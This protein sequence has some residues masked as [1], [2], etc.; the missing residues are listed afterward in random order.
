M[1]R[2]LP[3][4]AALAITAHC[5]APA[6]PAPTP[7]P[8]PPPP[9]AAAPAQPAAIGTVRVTAAT[10]NVRSE[11]STGGEI[12]A[13]VKKGEHLSLLATRGEWSN[14]RLQSGATGWVA[15][16]LVSAEGSS[17]APTPTRR[18]RSGCPADSDYR[19]AVP[20]VPSFSE[21]TT[22]H[23]V[24]T[25]EANVDT[26]GVV[27]STRLIANTTGDPTMAALA[28]KEIRNTRF[29]PPVRNCVAK[30]FIFTYRRSF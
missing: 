7:A 16:K 2:L 4:L 9:E 25:V 8:E 5:A 15:T 22:A 27:T 3:L 29:V 14:V 30:A 19:F 11:P 28:E 24:V 17:S 10:L 23:G 6:P 20:P 21:N 13:Q 18:S 26:R 12:V 1:R